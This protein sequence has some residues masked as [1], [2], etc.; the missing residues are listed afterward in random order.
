[1]IEGPRHKGSR[2]TTSLG[3]PYLGSLPMHLHGLRYLLLLLVRVQSLLL[4]PL[5][6][7]LLLGFRLL[8]PHYHRFR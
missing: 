7:D 8:P 2:A 4:R 3:E 6:S 5:A 1:M